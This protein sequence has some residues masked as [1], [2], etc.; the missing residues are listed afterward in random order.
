MMGGVEKGGGGKDS[1][2]MWGVGRTTESR[3]PPGKKLRRTIG[4]KERVVKWKASMWGKTGG[5]WDLGG[6]KKTT[7][8]L[9]RKES[10]MPGP[11]KKKKQK[12]K[13]GPSFVTAE[14]DHQFQGGGAKK[15]GGLYGVT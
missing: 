11:G 4:T 1:K 12:T 3:K 15:N 14:S 9:K 6:I 10:V 13:K 2:T 5:E 7:K 8:G